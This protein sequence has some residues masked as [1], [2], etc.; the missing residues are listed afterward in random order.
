MIL[1]NNALNDGKFNYLTTLIQNM[2]KIGLNKQEIY[3]MIINLGI[4]GKVLEETG[5]DYSILLVNK[6]NACQTIAQYKDKIQTQVTK[7]GIL[8]AQSERLKKKDTEKLIEELSALGIDR[9]FLEIKDVRN[10]YIAKQI[11]EGYDFKRKIR[12]DE[13]GCLI[14]AIL[15]NSGLNGNGNCF[16][17][18]LIYNLE[19]VGI[20]TQ[21]IYGMIINLGV[22]GNIIEET[23]YSYGHLLQN[24]NNA[25]QT[26]AR[27]KD[28][29]QTQVTETSILKAQS[30]NL[31]KQDVYGTIINLGVNK[32]VLDERGY[33]YEDLLTNKKDA[34]NLIVQYK[35]KIHTKVT[36]RNNFKNKFGKLK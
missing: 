28:K 30:E 34:C 25:C 15:N 23:G 1:D 29:M 22:N 12:D 8:K 4:N 5:F 36:K 6:N 19:Q 10:V 24:S 18:S 13:K 3:G 31:N 9:E 32:S 14:K 33:S 26:I 35:D 7:G 2:E 27:Y 21:E 11:I 17:T 16:L 20:N